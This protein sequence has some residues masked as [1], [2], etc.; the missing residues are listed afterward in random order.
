MLD[1][2][3]DMEVANAI[4]KTSTG[5]HTDADSVSQIDQRFQQLKLEECKPLDSKSKEYQALKNYLINTAG[6]TVTIAFYH[7]H[8]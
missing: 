3:T 1:T 5:R 4:M 6:H 8:L 7:A 2:L